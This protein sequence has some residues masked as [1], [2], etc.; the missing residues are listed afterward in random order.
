MFLLT[1]SRTGSAAESFAFGL[2][3]TGRVTLVGERTA[4]AGHSG[5]IRPV[6]HGFQ[7]F[8]PTGR[9][10]D[11]DTGETF[12]A[13]GIEP[14]VAV[15]YAEALREAHAMAVDSGREYRWY[16]E[17]KEDAA[18]GSRRRLSAGPRLPAA[19]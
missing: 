14:D 1:S 16:L 13:R 3:I 5:A 8:L 7:M 11:P 15:P 19:P 4:G 9:V 2:H 18:E 17:D 6:A 10:F 12:E